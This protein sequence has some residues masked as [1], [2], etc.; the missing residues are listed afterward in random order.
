MGV[1]VIVY[2]RLYAK[3]LRPFPGELGVLSQGFQ[4]EF[5]NFHNGHGLSL[6]FAF[7]DSTFQAKDIKRS[8]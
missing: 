3:L 4:V 5:R 2:T 7:R 6:D 8:V 1:A